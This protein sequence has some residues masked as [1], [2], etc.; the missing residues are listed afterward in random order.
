MPLV[1]LADP[2]HVGLYARVII[3]LRKGIMPVQVYSFEANKITR[4]RPIVVLLT[5]YSSKAPEQRMKDPICT[6]QVQY[7]RKH[8]YYN[9]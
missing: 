5:L 6:E 8:R 7:T 3:Q 2:N 9:L 4:Y 1:L